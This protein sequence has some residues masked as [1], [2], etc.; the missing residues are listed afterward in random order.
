MIRKEVYY[1]RNSIPAQLWTS[2]DTYKNDKKSEQYFES[3]GFRYR[4]V[5]EWAKWPDELWGYAVSGMA[6]DANGYLYASVRCKDSPIAVFDKDGQYVRSLGQNLPVA[7]LHGLFIDADQTIWVADDTQH[8]IFHL[9]KD[10]KQLGMLGKLGQPSDTGYDSTYRSPEDNS[11]P[12]PVRIV[13]ETGNLVEVL[14]SNTAYLSVKRLGEPFNK[15]TRLIRSADGRMF[16]TDGYGNAAVHCFDS[17]GSFV[18]SWG[19]PG[20]EPG[21]F[22]IPHS[23]WC[24]KRQHLWVCDRENN[25]MQVFSTEGQLLKVIDNLYFP[26][27]VWSDEQY[28]YVYEGEGRISIYNMD[29]ELLAQIG[30]WQCS[31]LTAH[32]MTGDSD[33][34]L[35]VADF[36]IKSIFKLE[37]M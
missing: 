36:G 8:V 29:Y 10:G 16:A 6:I 24:D 3:N 31:C 11:P 22:S 7:K 37:R 2:L 28:V 14:A 20:R 27:D 23:L 33:G 26:C 4:Y 17:S 18:C 25:R 35:Y 5:P 15:P 30:Y 32:S 9:L 1:Q 34:N 21:H 19:G 12:T 13:D